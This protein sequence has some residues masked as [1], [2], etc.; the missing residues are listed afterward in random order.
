MKNLLSVIVFT[1]IFFSISVF[2][3]DDSRN[4]LTWQVQKYDITATLPPNDA[5]QKS[6]GESRFE[7]EK[8]F[9]RVRQIL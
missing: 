7:S 2:A 9:E 6:F 5:G 4:L 8:Y 1:F 3:Q